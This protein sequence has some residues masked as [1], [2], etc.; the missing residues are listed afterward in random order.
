MFCPVDVLAIGAHPDDVELGCAGSLLKMSE[1]GRTIGIVDLTRGELGS[2]GTAGQRVQEA[3]SAAGL[4]SASFRENF[5]L[6]DG[7]IEVNSKSRLRLVEAI[8]SCR[9]SLVITH[10]QGIHPDHSKTRQLVDE[11]VHH[12]GLAKIETDSQRFRPSQVAYWLEFREAVIPGVLVDIT[13]FYDRKEEVLRAY[14][15]QIGGASEDEPETYLSRSDFLE[16][17]RAFHRHLGNLGGCPLAEGYRLSRPPR[18]IDLLQ[19]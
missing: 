1:E 5:E 17:V 11:A 18:M 16:Q 15:S 10:F 9:P 3:D 12:A 13:A 8:R 6:T 4:L 19:S 14:Q 7:D 2:R